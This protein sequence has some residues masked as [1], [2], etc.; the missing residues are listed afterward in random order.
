MLRTKRVYAPAEKSDGTRVL[1]MRL[2]PR[3]IKKSAVDLWLKELGAE[4]AN[5]RAFKAGRIGWPEMRRRYLAGL[6]REPAAGALRKLRAMARRGRV[7][8]LC[9]CEDEARCHRS[10]LRSVMAVLLALTLG[11]GFLVAPAGAEH[12]PQ[13]RYTVLGYVKDAAGR[14]RK[15]LGLEVTRQ[16]TGFT[17]VGETDDSGL[18]VIVTRLA[19]ES[20][21]ERLLVRAGPAS[22]MI[23]ARFSAADHTSE[24]GT[25]VDFTGSRVVERA[26]L[27]ASTLKRFLSK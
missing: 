23:A 17:Y 4:V 8:I 24:R 14:P 21:G 1:V 25:R 13:F 7:T 16:K 12:E 19:D 9:S 26:D 2:W 20:A 27:F 10:L 18:Y 15:G 11:A 6:E 22:L 5:L 3:G